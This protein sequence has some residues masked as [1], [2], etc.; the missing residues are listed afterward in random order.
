M[1]R[2]RSRDPRGR[3]LLLWRRGTRKCEGA[4]LRDLTQV[5]APVPPPL[6]TRPTGARPFEA[7]PTLSR[8]SSASQP[9]SVANPSVPRSVSCLGLLWRLACQWHAG[10]PISG[11]YVIEEDSEAKLGGT[12][13]AMETGRHRRGF[14]NYLR[15]RPG[16]PTGQL[17]RLAWPHSS[18]CWLEQRGTDGLSARRQACRF[19]PCPREGTVRSPGREALASLSPHC[20]SASCGNCLCPHLLTLF[21]VPTVQSSPRVSQAHKRNLIVSCNSLR[22]PWAQSLSTKWEPGTPFF[23]SPK[24]RT[25]SCYIILTQRN[26]FLGRADD[27]LSSTQKALCLTPATE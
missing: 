14:P 20:S 13:H 7:P 25:L 15:P 6:R 27:S 8:G 12:A 24:P 17:A 9:L 19:Q 23:L 3:R 26:D 10:H 21:P 16:L 2:G 1:S 22:V 5:P 18:S 11:D 4:G